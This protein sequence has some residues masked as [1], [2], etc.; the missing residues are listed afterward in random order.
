MIIIIIVV[1]D[2]NNIIIIIIIINLAC[3][4]IFFKN[5]DPKLFALLPWA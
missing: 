3:Q 4:H 1:A 2:A 5:S